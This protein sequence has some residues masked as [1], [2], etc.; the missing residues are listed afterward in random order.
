MEKA[1]WRLRLRQRGIQLPAQEQREEARQDPALPAPG[2]WT[3]G[4]LLGENAVLVFEAPKFVVT[5]CANMRTQKEARG[6]KRATG[7]VAERE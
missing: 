6:W 4:F 3:S 1:K 5:C 2:V 7:R